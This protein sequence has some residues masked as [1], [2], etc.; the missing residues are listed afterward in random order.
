MKKIA[1]IGTGAMGSIYAALF[2]EAGHSVV[3]I[4]IWEEHINQINTNGLIIDGA[5]GYKKVSGIKAY[6]N[7]KKSENFDIYIISTKAS[8]VSDVAKKLRGIVKKNSI[9]LT[10]QNG[11]GAGERI[12]KFLPSENILLGVA[13]GFGASIV[14]AGHIHHNAMRQIRLGEMNGGITK[15]LKSIENL[16]KKA[17]FNANAFEDIHKLIW[18]KFICN[19][20]LSAPCTV[21]ECNI[22]EILKNKNLKKIALGCMMEA[23]K[24]GLEKKINF[25]FSDPEKYVLDF[26]KVMPKANPS[27][28]LD[29]LSERKS[30]IDS[31]NGMVAK[32]SKN[33]KLEAPYNEILSEIVRQKEKKF[34]K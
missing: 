32:L 13:E 1:I 15:R 6:S 3:A 7:I 4:D 26:A 33:F 29:H 24:I 14:S 8:A 30:E 25:S 28:R 18:E 10:I 9:I 19:V 5:S 12:S 2:K 27:M 16:W 34:S 17:G 20:F 31:I 21:F 11:L 22:G 23:Y